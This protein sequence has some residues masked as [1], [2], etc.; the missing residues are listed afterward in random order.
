MQKECFI[1]GDNAFSAIGGVL[2]CQAHRAA[3]MAEIDTL[4]A[5]GK[6][7]DATRIA[8]E[9]REPETP[10]KYA[11]SA[12]AVHE[13]L[14]KN[15]ITGSDAARMMY[16]SGSRQV[17]KYTG[18]QKPRQMD[19]ARWFCLHAHTILSAEDIAKIETAMISNL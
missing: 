17:R 18:G 4:R 5:A 13:F 9:M 8:Y 6:S 11:P 16:L 7:V 3:V 10:A 12:K 1:C 14:Q 19:G 15:N 2:L